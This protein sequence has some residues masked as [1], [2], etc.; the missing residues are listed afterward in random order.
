MIV[1]KGGASLIKVAD[2]WRSS[3]CD[4]NDV[5]QSSEPCPAGWKGIIENKT[6]VQCAP[7]H[8][9]TGGQTNCQP[10]EPGKVA[11]ARGSPNC[12]A[13]NEKDNMYS[14]EFGASRCKQCGPDEESYAGKSCKKAF[15]NPDLPTPDGMPS[16]VRIPLSGAGIWDDGGI[17]MIVS[18]SKIEENTD[19]TAITPTALELQISILPDFS[20]AN[21]THQHILLDPGSTSFTTTAENTPSLPSFSRKPLCDQVVYA[22][23]RAINDKEQV[24]TITGPWGLTSE[25]WL[26][27]GHGACQKSTQY[28]DCSSNTSQSPQNW[29]CADCPPGGFCEGSV[30]WT[31]VRA[32]PGFWRDN[33]VAATAR[34]KVST[35]VPREHKFVAC[36]NAGACEGGDN[37]TEGCA[38]KYLQICNPATNGTCRLCRTCALGH[39]MLS[40]GITCEVCPELGS[41][42]RKLAVFLAAFVTGMVLVIFCVLVYL[43]L[44]SATK[45]TLQKDKAAHSTIKRIVLSHMQIIMLSLSLRVPW[46]RLVVSMMVAFSSVSSVSRHVAQVG[47]FVDTEIPV[48]KQARFLYSSAVS[49]AAFPIMFSSLLWIYWLVFVPLRC[50]KKL[51]CGRYEDLTMSDPVPNVIRNFLHPLCSRKETRKEE[52]STKR[53]RSLEATVLSVGN[54]VVAAVEAAEAA[55]KIVAPDGT[56]EYPKLC[57]LL[58][59]LK[60]GAFNDAFSQ[61]G[62]HATKQLVD[63]LQE[64]TLINMGM[65]SAQRGRMFKKIN[66]I[67]ENL[68][69]TWQ[70]PKPVQTSVGDSDSDR[71]GHRRLNSR[72]LSQ[73]AKK[74]QT[75]DASAT[76]QERQEQKKKLRKL[77]MKRILE[78]KQVK[79][80][81]V[82]FY[83]CV[84]FLYMLYP[85]LCRF[86]MSMMSCERLHPDVHD[87]TSAWSTNAYLR[88][89][90]EELCGGENHMRY[91]W[92]IAIPSLL[93]YALG[94]PAFALVVL[95]RQRKFHRSKKYLF[96][97]GLIYSGYKKERWWWEGIV[98]LRKLSIIFFASFF[99]DS[100]IQLQLTLG[101]MVSA[102]TMHHMFVP[103]GVLKSAAGESAGS[104]RN[105][106]RRERQDPTKDLDRLERNSILVCTL[107]LWSATV[108]IVRE[109]CENGFCYLLVIVTLLSNVWFLGLG[110]YYYFRH[111]T[112]RNKTSLKQ[113]ERALRGKMGK[114]QRVLNM[115]KT[116]EKA[117]KA[118]KLNPMWN[119]GKQG[120]SKRKGA[121]S[122]PPPPNRGQEVELTNFSSAKKTK[123]GKPEQFYQYVSEEGYKYYV[124]EEGEPVWKLPSNA[125]VIVVEVADGT[126]AETNPGD[127]GRYTRFVS[128]DVEYFVSEDWSET[129]WELPEGAVLIG[130]RQDSEAQ[131]GEQEEQEEQEMWVKISEDGCEYFV[132]ESGACV[133]A[134]PEGAMLVE[135]DP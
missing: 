37:E 57:D 55:E 125:E 66:Q 133:W 2:G 60:L 3:E 52:P 32:A 6:C 71:K 130:G 12:T 76:L 85:S 107:L 126:D 44:R 94:L 72:S 106:I 39:A 116:K 78:D 68:S 121:T 35:I 11:E 53:S 113:F 112:K 36:A 92:L 62:I 79:T 96:R 119:R 33:R 89:D 99:Y 19:T 13:C 111:W 41:D 17:D 86:P 110:V 21:S 105:L 128:E 82:W 7:G 20:S 51:S 80:R 120:E 88:F 134:L 132:N 123:S 100:A 1:A 69:S 10:C 18:W 48:G 29:S 77:A 115:A 124:S 129:L 40:D 22:R 34:A 102:F 28:L 45:A 9:T 101:I 43:H 16:I 135:Y 30:R 114:L 83:S 93:G 5:C 14:D 65:R 47:C 8:T 54:P 131:H 38:A 87:S 61:H 97:M 118:D 122:P 46:P 127:R 90:A 67:K 56:T 81:D 74:R 58:K 109:R 27:T 4:L 15:G 117:H 26:S 50:C 23:L 73:F 91:V 59:D 49:V 70:P 31:E 104:S 103:F 64:S 63:D 84:L 98:V 95:W 25:K 108:Y 75:L 42:E 24:T